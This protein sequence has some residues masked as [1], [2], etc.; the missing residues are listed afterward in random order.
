ME[1]ASL[2]S[3]FLIGYTCVQGRISSHKGGGLIPSDIILCEQVWNVRGMMG[4]FTDL[5]QTLG[6]DLNSDSLYF[7]KS[8]ISVFEVMQNIQDY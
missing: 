2:G 1:V 8:Y 6:F 3:R 5:R 7:I 4:L